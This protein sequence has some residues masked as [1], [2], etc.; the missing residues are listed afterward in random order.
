MRSL[1]LL[2]VSFPLMLHAQWRSTNGPR[3]PLDLRDLLVTDSVV[4]AGTTCGT[5]CSTDGGV[6][7]SPV[8]A[9]TF[10]QAVVY[11]GT[12]YATVAG[13]CRLLPQGAQW[14]VEPVAG[15]GEVNDL[16]A[17]AE[18]LAGTDYGGFRYSINGVDWS[19]NN[20][21]L[22]RDSVYLPSGLWGYY[23][24]AFAVT[25]D[26]DYRYVGTPHGVYRTAAPGDPWSVASS[27]LPDLPVDHLVHMDGVLMAALGNT[28]YRSVD[29]ADGWQAVLSLPEGGRFNRLVEAGGT[30]KACTMEHGLWMSS[31]GGQSWVQEG[32]G[33][34]EADVRDAVLVD[35]TW[36]VATARSLYTGVT[37]YVENLEGPVCCTVMDLGTVGGTVVATELGAAHVMAAPGATWEQGTSG[38]DIGV[39]FDV[40]VVDGGYLLSVVPSGL[41]PATCTNYRASSAGMEWTAVSTFVNYGDPYFLRS[42]GERVVAYTDALL[43][44]SQDAA[45]TWTDITPAVGLV[46]NNFSDV[47]WYGDTLFLVSCSAG[48]VLRS[49]DLGAT[50]TFATN[51]LPDLEPYSVHSLPTGLFVTNNAGLYRS[52]DGGDSWSFA[53]SGLP[54]PDS[55]VPNGAVQD[56]AAYPPYTFLCTPDAVYVSDAAHGAWTD[57][58]EGLPDP[59]FLYAGALLVKE[60]TLYFGTN[61]HGVYKLGLDQLALAVPEAVA[62][63][64]LTLHPNPADEGISVGDGSVRELELTD[65]TGRVTT[66]SSLGDGRFAVGALPAGLYH[67]RA[68]TGT[69]EL[70][71]GRVVVR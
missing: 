6:E 44:L 14:V 58:S 49:T 31:D 8:L 23:F 46:C 13:L 54:A 45:L 42:N 52:V 5:F 28:A 70:R 66:M 53:G 20:S 62:A 24:N 4:L 57:I 18:L 68:I 43:Y 37:S 25:A 47:A 29:G 48:D 7:W 26:A 1:L 35:G 64:S 55:S 71:T 12:V 11:Q 63:G 51:G 39:M 65:A 38:L 41:G 22:P 19:V 33:V 36:V 3:G 50:W 32:A 27:G 16:C 15:A 2:I 21:G 9:G 10:E 17:G 59:A 61:G 40:A 60:D 30:W 67:V 69:G 56:L 34:Q